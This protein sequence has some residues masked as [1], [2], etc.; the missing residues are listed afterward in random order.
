[1]ES[2]VEALMEVYTRYRK[3]QSRKHTHSFKSLE[4]EVQQRGLGVP[5]RNCHLLFTP[6]I[7]KVRRGRGDRHAMTLTFLQENYQ[8]WTQGLLQKKT[9]SL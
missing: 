8:T 5:G 1:M 9:S 6:S 2:I 7:P 3:V 4:R